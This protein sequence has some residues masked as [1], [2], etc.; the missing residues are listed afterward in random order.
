[1][2]VITRRSLIFSGAA[3]A[4]GALL[5]PAEAATGSFSIRIVSAGFI[6]GASVGSGILRFQGTD[7][8]L[9]VGGISAGAT[10]GASG[11][12]LVG[13]AYHLRQPADIEGI[14]SAV[15]AGLSVAGG[16]SVAQLTNSRGVVLRLHGRQMGLM[17]SID[18][19][20]MSISLAS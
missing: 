4:S 20:G 5:T 19:S 6:F 18:L 14:Y 8:R 12:D 10:I 15:G 11:T 7:F 16:R 1:M 17:F 2:N 9:N 13:T 3:L